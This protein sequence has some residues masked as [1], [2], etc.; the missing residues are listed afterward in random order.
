MSQRTDKLEQS[1]LTSS[2][3][4][5]IAVACFQ[6]AHIWGVGWLTIA[7]GYALIELTRQPTWRRTF[8]SLLLVGIGFYGPQLSFFWGIFGGGAIA[9]WLVL[10]FWVALFGVL[11]RQSREQFGE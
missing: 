6:A 7:Y 1:W 2:A 9:L 5:L 3:W 11:L 10:A 8:S 4:A